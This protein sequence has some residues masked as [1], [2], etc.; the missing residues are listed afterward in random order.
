LHLNRI[1]TITRQNQLALILA[2]RNLMH[3]NAAH[4][5]IRQ[6]NLRRGIHKVQRLT[7]LQHRIR[8]QG[9]HRSINARTDL[10]RPAIGFGQS[11]TDYLRPEP[12]KIV[13]TAPR[14]GP[15]LLKRWC[16]SHRTAKAILPSREDWIAFM[17]FEHQLGVWL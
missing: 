3:S 14:V 12:A 10:Q 5:L 9:Q 7:T 16:P 15:W 17:R 2:R 1:S 13:P 11:I 4:T 6:R 8:D